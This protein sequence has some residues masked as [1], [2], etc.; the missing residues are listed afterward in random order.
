MFVSLRRSGE[1]NRRGGAPHEPEWSNQEVD[2]VFEEGGLIPFDRM[3]NKLK[4]PADN[5]QQQR[6]APIEKEQRPRH[7]DHRYADAVTEPVQRM[8][9]LGP[10]VS[11]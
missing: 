8:L 7:G 10:V 3:S 2:R 5:K 6:P 11:E 4:N 9:M 1:P